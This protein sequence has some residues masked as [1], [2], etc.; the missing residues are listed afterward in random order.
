MAPHVTETT[1]SPRS[2]S[3]TPD[4]L[5]EVENLGVRAEPEPKEELRHEQRHMMARAIDP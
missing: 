5:L 2:A 4:A 1:V 3:A